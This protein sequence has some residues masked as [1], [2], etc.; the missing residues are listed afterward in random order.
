MLVLALAALLSASPEN[1]QAP[2]VVEKYLTAGRA[3]EAKRVALAKEAQKDR[4]TALTK[5]R[6]VLLSYLEHAAF[7]AWEGT[8]WDFNGTSTTPGEGVIACGYYVSTVLVQA[9][10][11]VERVR[12][13]QQA[14]MFIVTTL[15]RGSK[16]ERLTPKDNAEAL[17]QIRDRFP[18]AELVVIGFDYHVGFLRLTKDGA[19]F[20][21]SSYLEPGGVT[22]EDP[23][24]SG[25]FASKL[26]V[27]ADALN[28]QLLD[29]WLQGRAIKTERGR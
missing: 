12:L 26:Y 3:L 7:P 19:A 4:A 15:A 29:D 6:Q 13:A 10:V 1:V 22:C 2:T 16:V 8:V 14:S 5:A 17:D 25:A 23:V 28:D 18:H 27:V 9:G 24:A 21:H 20:C 11:K